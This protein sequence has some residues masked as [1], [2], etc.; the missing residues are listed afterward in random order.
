M[1]VTT[2]TW[3]K[4]ENVLLDVESTLNNRPLGYV[5]DDIDMPVLTPNTMILGQDNFSLDP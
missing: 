3:T 5:E 2:L 1:G 4:L